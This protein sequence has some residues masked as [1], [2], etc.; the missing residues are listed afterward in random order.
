M[1]SVEGKYDS[2]RRAWREVRR[3][4]STCER[5]GRLADVPCW[6][7][8]ICFLPPLAFWY[9]LPSSSSSGPAFSRASAASVIISSVT[10]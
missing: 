7:G 9:A 3:L 4:A 10:Q 2:A 5:M 6:W 8:W 1:A